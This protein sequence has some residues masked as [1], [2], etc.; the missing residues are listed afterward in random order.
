MPYKIYRAGGHIL[1]EDGEQ[2]YVSPQNDW[3]V[4]INRDDLHAQISRELPGLS[5]AANP[6]WSSL[7]APIGTQEVWAAGVTYLRSKN[8]RM[9]ES[10]ESGGADFYDKVY[11]AERP[12]IFFK[13]VASRVIPSNGY[14]RIRKDSNWN[15]PEPE[16]TLV[17]TSSGTIVGYTIGN[18]MSSRSIEGENPLYLPQAKVYDGSAAIGPCVLVTPEP[19]SMQ[20]TIA[21]RILRNGQLAFEGATTTGQMKRRYT[22]LVE[23]L[24]RE[25][26]FPA[27]AYLM[28][29]TCVVPDADF[30]LMSGDVIR[31]TIE[32]IGELVNTVA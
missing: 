25:L 19:P 29:G 30:T 15:V 27:G 26:G 22:E 24:Y 20:T 23:F 21:M 2:L 5:P 7:Q 28:T 16:L 17:V 13:S 32:G 1:I 31:I 8:A 3:D 10:K 6:D 18:D 4:F 12:E 14:V 11:E 9:E